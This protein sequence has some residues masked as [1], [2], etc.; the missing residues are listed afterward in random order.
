MTT[1]VNASENVQ[2]IIAC[3]AALDLPRSAAHTTF[4]IGTTD[5]WVF[6]LHS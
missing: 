6:S 1:L 3:E 5:K 4:S 2:V